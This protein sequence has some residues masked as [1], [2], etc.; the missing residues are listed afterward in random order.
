MSDVLSPT[1]P[2]LCLSTG[3][4]DS[5]RIG[6]AHA[7]PHHRV[8][9]RGGFLRRHAAQQDGHQQRG[10]LVVGQRAVGDAGHEGVDGGPVEHPAIPFLPYQVDR[11]HVEGVRSLKADSTI[12]EFARIPR[13]PLRT[14]ASERSEMIRS[15][16]IRR[17][18][19]RSRPTPPAA[20]PSS[21]ASARR[22]RAPCRSIRAATPRSASRCRGSSRRRRS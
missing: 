15:C 11:A 7:G 13:E 18:L 14:I 20:W 10:R 12:L 9:Q 22:R 5:P 19:P 3:V 6:H 8:G 1:P 17:R 4:P 16:P 21:R 2:V